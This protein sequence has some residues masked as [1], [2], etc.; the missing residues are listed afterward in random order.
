MERDYCSAT[1]RGKPS[2][3]L[4]SRP[5]SFGNAKEVEEEEMEKAGVFGIAL[6]MRSEGWKE[7]LTVPTSHEMAGE[8]QKVSAAVHC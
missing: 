6:Q 8:V 4:K 2:E 3:N 5:G 7:T 1:L